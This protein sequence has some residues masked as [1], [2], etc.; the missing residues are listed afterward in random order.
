MG[1]SGKNTLPHKEISSE[2]LFKGHA[3]RTNA[4]CFLT[5]KSGDRGREKVRMRSEREREKKPQQKLV[6]EKLT[7]GI[8]SIYL[9]LI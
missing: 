9:P 5:M 2:Y 8:V 1:S 7:T 3:I 6:K 4:T